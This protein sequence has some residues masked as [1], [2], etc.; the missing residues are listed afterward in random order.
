MILHRST[1]IALIRNTPP[2]ELRYNHS[3]IVVSS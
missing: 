3:G 1:F 2:E